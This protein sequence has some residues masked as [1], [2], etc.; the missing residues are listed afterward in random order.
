MSPSRSAPV[1]RYD[2]Y[3]PVHKGL[4]LALSDLL[5]RL[6]RVDPGQPSAVAALAADLRRQLHLSAVHLDNE[7]REVHGALRRRAPEAVHCL[8]TAHDE[9]RHAFAE[10]ERLAA[11]AEEADAAA[12]PAALRSLYLRFSR[13]V[14]DDFAHMAEEELTVL[15]VLHRLFTDE[16]LQEMEERIVAAE[17]PGDLL[18]MARMVVPAIDP[19][20]RTRMLGSFRTKA[21]AEVFEA[22]LEHAVRPSLPIEEWHRLSTEL[23]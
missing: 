6:G 9:H 20:E 19:V 11:R 1:A 8:A 7:N 12:R 10:I 2:F 23:G 16:E 5:V 4:R 13:F 15:P 18:A 17:A 21:P 22:V 14:A 3:G